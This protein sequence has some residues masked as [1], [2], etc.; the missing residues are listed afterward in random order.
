MQHRSI[1]RAGPA[2]YPAR[3]RLL[4]A[5]AACG[6][7][8]AIAGCGSAPKTAFDL[9]AAGSGR[10]GG[11]GAGQ[12]VVAEPSALQAFESERIAVKDAAGAVSLLP[13]G[14]WADRLPRLFQTRLVQSFEN[15]G[16]ARASRPGD[17]VTPDGQLNTDI[18]FFGLDAS[19][20]EAVVEVWA[21]LLDARS[22]RILR[23]RLFVGRAPVG[24]GGAGEVA[25]TLNRVST[26]VL[27]DIVRWTGSGP[28]PAPTL[29]AGT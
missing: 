1:F 11:A 15:T 7:V 24:A 13:D 18:R 25:Q 19:R 28:G 10:S 29:R 9:S 3:N 16:R 17:G 26:G 14:Q 8:L 21:R 27:T 20:S 23:A 22:G 4:A 5:A 12:I 2:D 6:A